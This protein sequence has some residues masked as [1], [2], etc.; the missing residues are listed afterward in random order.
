MNITA[1]KPTVAFTEGDLEA[2]TSQ[3]DVKTRLG[4]FRLVDLAN[5]TVALS[6]PNYKGRVSI[7]ASSTGALIIEVSE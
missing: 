7:R 6:A 3:L 5:G 1:Y 4:A 2:D